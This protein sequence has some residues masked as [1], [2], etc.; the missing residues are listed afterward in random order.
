MSCDD[1]VCISPGLRMEREK[2]KRAGSTSCWFRHARGRPPLPPPGPARRRRRRV[3]RQGKPSA[4]WRRHSA[5]CPPA[6]HVYHG[7]HA[8]SHG[9]HTHTL[10]RTQEMG[11]RR[12]QESCRGFESIELGLGC[13]DEGQNNR[14]LLGGSAGGLPSNVLATTPA[15]VTPSRSA[16]PRTIAVTPEQTREWWWSAVALVREVRRGRTPPCVAKSTARALRGRPAGR[17]RF[18][19]TW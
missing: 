8:R 5:A 15:A 4:L 11:R 9:P 19:P 13:V 3:A 10:A 17:A 12:G 18:R 7:A 2:R 6:H 16:R 14:K 1:S